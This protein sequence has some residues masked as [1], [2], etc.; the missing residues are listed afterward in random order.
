M[1]AP[2]RDPSD[3][4][5]KSDDQNRQR[6]P[7]RVL[8]SKRDNRYISAHENKKNR[9]TLKSTRYTGSQSIRIMM[10]VRRGQLARRLTPRTS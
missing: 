9:S 3:K 7:L 10:F 4:R 1:A 8:Q 5:W 6:C 2:S